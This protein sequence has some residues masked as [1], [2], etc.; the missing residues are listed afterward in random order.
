MVPRFLHIRQTCEQSTCASSCPST[1]TC[2]YY[3]AC[4]SSLPKDTM[5][6][7]SC[8][9]V[10]G[11]S[12]VR[13]LMLLLG[14]GVLGG[15]SESWT[16]IDVSYRVC[17]RT[18]V[19]AFGA[20]WRTSGR[21]KQHVRWDGS[22]DEEGGRTDERGSTYEPTNSTSGEIVLDPKRMQDWKTMDS[23]ETPSRS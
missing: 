3:A 21:T 10:F 14:L 11:F 17:I 6:H 8:I 13:D 15:G 19:D 23:Y 7:N 5:V 9:V 2:L 12:F 16:R 4:A 18:V 1:D 20:K 22:H